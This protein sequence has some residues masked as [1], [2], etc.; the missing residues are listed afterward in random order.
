MF[1]F[2]VPIIKGAIIKGA[3]FHEQS[4]QSILYSQNQFWNSGFEA[5]GYAFNEAEGEFVGTLV[6]KKW[7]KKHNVIRILYRRIII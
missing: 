1:S 5:K 7:G 4:N 2:F 6:C 3:I